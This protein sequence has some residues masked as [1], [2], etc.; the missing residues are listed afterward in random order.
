M[1]SQC[2]CPYC[3]RSFGLSASGQPVVEPPEE[4]CEELSIEAAE[5]VLGS[6]SVGKYWCSC[7]KCDYSWES[8]IR[9][10]KRCP[11][12]GSY[13]WKNGSVT[14]DCKRC[15]HVWGCRKST[16]P[17]RCPKC[18][19]VYWDKPKPE[20]KKAQRM[21]ERSAKGQYDDRTEEAVTRCIGGESLYDVC[22]EMDVSV[23]EVAMIIKGRG[24]NFSV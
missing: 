7:S 9:D 24:E 21:V 4:P 12:C 11:N 2:T 16:P 23:L 8:Q 6:P 10:P 1:I 18:R 5:E 13:H 15:G 19:S 3:N 22:V 14:L 20:P 17:L